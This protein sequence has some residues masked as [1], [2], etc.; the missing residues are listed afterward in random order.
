[1]STTI[2]AGSGTA[3]PSDPDFPAPGTSYAGAGDP[4][5]AGTGNV[6][7]VVGATQDVNNLLI[8]AEGRY[9]VSSAVVA[10]TKT[11]S[12]VVDPFG[13][14]TLVP[15]AVITYT[16]EVEVSGTGTAEALAI[17]DLIPAEL[18]YLAGTLAVSALPAGEEVDDDFAPV[19]IDNTGFDAGTQTVTVSLSDVAGGAPVITITF[20]AAIR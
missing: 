17:T 4:D 13:G 16:L 18:E 10:L 7:A 1:V 19:G 3:D 6:I 12:N 11:A 2:I 5:E 15:G 9:V 8:S 20:D 14:A